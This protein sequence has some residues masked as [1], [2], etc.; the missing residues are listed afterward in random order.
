QIKLGICPPGTKL[1]PRDE[2]V[3]EWAKLTKEEKGLYAHQTVVYAADLSFV[4]HW[5]G[6]LVAFLEEIG[7][8]D[9]TLIITVTDNGASSE[10]GPNGSFSE[11]LFLNNV[12]QTIE[13]NMKHFKEWGGPSTYC[14]YSWGW[15]WA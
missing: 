13:L 2:V 1:S 7:Q 6:E 10:G 4:E 11:N 8:L 14:H 15:A 3:P 12:P 9:N 5:V